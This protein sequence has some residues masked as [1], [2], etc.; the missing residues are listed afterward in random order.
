[1]K[2]ALIGAAAGIMLLISLGTVFGDPM[3]TPGTVNWRYGNLTGSSPGNSSPAIG[4]DGTIYYGSSDGYLYGLNP[5]GALRWRYNA[6][7][8]IN[9]PPVI[10]PD[11]TIY[12]RSGNG[13]LHSVNGVKNGTLNWFYSTGSTVSTPAIG[14][15]GTVYVGTDNSLVALNPNGTLK[16]NLTTNGRPTS[17]PAFGPDGT[18]W[19][20]T[21]SGLVALHPNG[22]LKSNLTTWGGPTSPPAIGA[23]GTIHGG[24]GYNLL[25]INPNGTLKSNLTAAARITSSPVIGPGGTIWITTDNGIVALHPNGTPKCNLT[26]SSMSMVQGNSSPVIGND[27]TIYYGIGDRINAL[28]DNC[29]QIWYSTTGGVINNPT[30]TTPGGKVVFGSSDGYVYN[31]HSSSTGLANSAWPQY[32]RD[33][34]HTGNSACIYTLST[35]AAGFPATSSQ[36]SVTV[37]TS[38]PYCPWT[39]GSNS[40]WLTL[41][42]GLMGTGN[43]TVTFTVNQYGESPHYSEGAISAG[44]K[45]STRTGTITIAGKTFAVMQTSFNAALYFP[46][47]D[48]NLPWQTEIAVVNTGN[49]TV[50]GTL[51]ALSN[52][53]QLEGTLEV[54][55]SA[56]GRRQIIVAD[57]FANH[58]NIGYII[59]DTNSSYVQGYA[60]FYQAGVYRAAIPAV[61]EVNTGDIN[62]SH[63][64]SSAQWWTGVSLVNTTAATKELTITFNNGVSVPYTLNAYQH[65]VFTIGSLLNEPIQPNIHSAVI[66]NASGVIG[67]ELFG[68]TGSP[69]QLEGILLTDKTASTLYYP[70]V[71]SNG[72]WTGIVAYDP[73]W[74][75]CTLTILS[76]SAAGTYLSSTT[77]PLAG[78]ENYVGTVAQ[79]GLPAETAWFRLD[80]TRPI[81]G[82]EL[83]GTTNGNQLAA[84]AGR[85]GTGS[86]TG[87]FPKIEKSGWTGIAFVNTEDGAASVTLTAYNDSGTVVAT[88]A[89]PVAGHAK[90]VN[91]PEQIFT[92]DIS[93][94]TYIAYTAD[95]NVVGFQLNGS[96]DGMM[97]DGLPGLGGTN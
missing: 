49:Q 10:N 8:A 13:I 51:R 20:A 48:T 75:P 26:S 33:P 38:S 11:G 66:S 86:K 70:H 97:L 61:K 16:S 73:S 12:V 89:L 90:V 6:G 79:L 14:A 91:V 27:G 32:G 54:T 69:N 58:T 63:I 60:K 72:W 46:H 44:T 1:M 92:Q 53:G 59:L 85:G 9:S 74:V 84:Y 40:S 29:N 22:T 42:T 28:D 78:R 57:E 65:R 17:P 45:G 19:V 68:S 41:A 88:R 87:V 62:I 47:I 39:A 67:L 37:T 76:Y 50:T 43:G 36:G 52:E 56:H 21:G 30:I 7:S 25:T 23:D 64:D 35:N 5:D 31:F 18:I 55:L 80:S 24:W 4:P 34:M 93:S 15:D 82:F 71:D 81:T 83:F 94:A 95:K 77:L 2:K 96:S 3:T